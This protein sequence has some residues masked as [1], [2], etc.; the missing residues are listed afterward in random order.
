MP[1]PMPQ[2]ESESPIIHNRPPWLPPD[3][4]WRPDPGRPWKPLP[5][6]PKQEIQ[7]NIRQNRPPW[8]P[9]LENL[10]WQK[11]KP[12]RGWRQ[13]RPTSKPISPWYDIKFLR[14]VCIYPPLTEKTS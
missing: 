6:P 11:S 9:P 4:N 10:D 7:P 12:D 14:E 8:L 3:H 1:E 2:P 13:N 5:K